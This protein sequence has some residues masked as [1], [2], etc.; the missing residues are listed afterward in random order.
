[1]DV[2]VESG[3]SSLHFCDD[4]LLDGIEADGAAPD[5]VERSRRDSRLWKD[6][7]KPQ[8]LDELSLAAIAHAGFEQPA[9]INR[10]IVNVD[11]ELY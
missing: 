10:S 3:R 7:H 9:Q 2:Q 6:L 8:H 5:R 4:E 11:V 1:V